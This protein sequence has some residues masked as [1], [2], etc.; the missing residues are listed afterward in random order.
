[1]MIM[2]QGLDT[3]QMERRRGWVMGAGHKHAG[4]QLMVPFWFLGSPSGAGFCPNCYWLSR[5]HLQ[6]SRGGKSYLRR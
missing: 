5:G 6:G 1:M 2:W 4:W 3:P